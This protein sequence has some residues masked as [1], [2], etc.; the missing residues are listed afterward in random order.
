MDLDK[1]ELEDDQKIEKIQSLLTIV[2]ISDGTQ[3]ALF[4]NGDIYQVL[5]GNKLK[6]VNDLIDKDSR[7]KEKIF[8]RFSDAPND[9]KNIG[10]EAPR[11][12]KTLT[13]KDIE[14]P[15]L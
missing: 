3:Y 7:L 9:I 13:E 1:L 10:D 8:S 6:K 5:E 2:T 14:L 11:R 15:E 12:K 4:K